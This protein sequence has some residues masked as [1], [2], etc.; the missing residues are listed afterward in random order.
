MSEGGI[1]HL[2]CTQCEENP[3]YALIDGEGHLVCHCTHVDGALDPWPLHGFHGRPG[4]WE[5]V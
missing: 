2:R 5:Y 4:E 3:T 1:E